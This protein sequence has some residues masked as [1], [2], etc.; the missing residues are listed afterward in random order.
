MPLISRVSSGSRI[1]LRLSFEL[2][3][4]SWQRRS[5]LLHLRYR[6]RS[7][8]SARRLRTPS[9][10]SYALS[11]HFVSTLIERSSSAGIASFCL[12]LTKSTSK[13]TFGSIPFPSGLRNA[14]SC[15]TNLRNSQRTLLSR[16]R[17]TRFVQLPP[18]WLLCPRSPWNKFLKPALGP[19][20][21]LSLP[22]ILGN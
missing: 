22:F 16:S 10:T 13:R 7:P 1:S 18:P 3:L 15:V 14:L 12:F 4:P 17:H 6:S 5:W 20:T 21:I 8:P 11:A 2:S 9:I 19:T